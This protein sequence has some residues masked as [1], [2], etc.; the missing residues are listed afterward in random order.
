MADASVLRPDLSLVLERI[1]D[2][3][4]ALDADWRVTYVNAEAR[5]LL[6]ADED[7]LGRYWLDVF[8]KARGQ[9]FEREYNRAMRSGASRI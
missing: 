4:M 9:L 1:T 3:F 7:V 2:G 6:H 5:R 8:P